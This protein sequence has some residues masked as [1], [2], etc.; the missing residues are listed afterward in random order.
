MGTMYIMHEPIWLFPV[1]ALFKDT[2]SPDADQMA[3]VKGNGFTF[4]GDNS[5]K[6][7][8]LPSEKESTLK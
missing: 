6:L 1:D 3:P 8:C 5:L 7:V 4:K 2:F